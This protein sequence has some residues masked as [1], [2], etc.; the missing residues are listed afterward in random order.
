[1]KTLYQLLFF[2]FMIES[3]ETKFDA[4]PVFTEAS[5]TVTTTIRELKTR[6]IKGNFELITEDIVIAGIVIAD[7]R[8]GNFY[9][10]IILQ[11]ASGGIAIRLDGS[12]L[13]NNFPVGRKVYV[14]LKGL[15]LSDY[16]GLI[17]LGGGIDNTDPSKLELAGIPSSLFDKYLLKGSLGNAVKP[18]VVNVND[19]TTNI[20]DTLQ[21][22]LIELHGYEFGEVD[23]SKT[24]APPQ[25]SVNLIATNCSG[26]SVLLRNSGYSNFAGIKLPKGNGKL[27]A[28]YS[29]FGS[30][31][32]LMLRDTADV[33]FTGIRCK[34]QPQPVLITIATLRSLYK[35][36]A[37]TIPDLQL[38][39]GI[40]ITDKAA[41]N[42]DDDK[43]IIQ[44]IG[45]QSAI[46][47]QFTSAHNYS[48]GDEVQLNISKQELN[49]VNN[50][51]AIT[52]MSTDKAVKIGTG[53]ITAKVATVN[54]MIQQYD[55][56]ESSLV[57]IINLTTDA[58]TWMGGKQIKDATG[59]IKAVVK[60]AATFANENVP[61]T[62]FE[63]TGILSANSTEKFILFRNTNDIILNAVVTPPTA[64][65]GG[66]I[67]QGASVVFDFNDI[68][69]AIPEGV[70][71][72]TNA[73]NKAL[74]NKIT[75]NTAKAQWG[76]STG[77]FK[78]YASAT[79]LNKSSDATV[80][81]ASN[82]RALGIRQVGTS[83]TFPDSDPGAAFVFEI[84]NT[85]GKTNLELAF[86]LQSL[87]I[88]SGRI[89]AWTIDYGIG[90]TPASFIPVTTI[91]GSMVTGNLIFSDNNIVAKLPDALNNL[92]S[93]IW[94][95]IATLS[96]TTGSGSRPSSA[97]DDVKFSWK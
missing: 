19:L 27:T 78:N 21:N 36:A 54:E 2:C 86:K 92:S 10:S 8:S 61:A 80:Q 93:K 56:W 29:I 75:F 9:K 20:Q 37:V 14:K 97:I 13:Y 53:A 26:T 11:D 67:L 96:A 22:T 51:L 24:Y 44:Q 23:T 81:D 71:I 94:I 43:M 33:H 12:G 82:D 88:T 64:P 84:A 57:K 6:H 62:G 63:M 38:V 79:G 30:T 49:K 46:V 66:I 18:N 15:Y 25:T 83:T 74:G 77:N 48:L 68:S 72:R 85:T 35:N 59:S 39:K 47:I 42:F 73:T 41:K 95:R 28:V 58:G 76:N 87:D 65:T 5:I 32:Q 1:M 40:V 45:T 52:K 17:Q 55:N 16:G 60:D 34:E 90:E 91:T 69:K 70:T 89:T 50:V 31:K 7:D 3:C 4:P